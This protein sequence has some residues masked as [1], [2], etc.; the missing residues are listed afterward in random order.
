MSRFLIGLDHPILRIMTGSQIHSDI[1]DP[2]YASREQEIE[3]KERAVKLELVL[4]VGMLV[5]VIV[6]FVIVAALG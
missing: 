4:A 1:K 5:V 2:H 6:T 3:A